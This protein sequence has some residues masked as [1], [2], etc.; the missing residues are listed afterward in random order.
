MSGAAWLEPP[1]WE[2]GWCTGQHVHFGAAGSGFTALCEVRRLLAGS[3]A[4]L[5]FRTLPGVSVLT[6]ELVTRVPARWGA[7]GPSGSFANSHL[8]SV[9]EDSILLCSYMS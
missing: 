8:G 9:S 6:L 3:V 7:A 5:C 1:A 2:V 4:P